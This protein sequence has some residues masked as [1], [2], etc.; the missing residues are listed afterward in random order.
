MNKE[1]L[2]RGLNEDLAAE[3]G[4]VI[5]YTYQSAKCCGLLAAELRELLIKEEQDEL[6]HAAFLMDVIEELESA[7]VNS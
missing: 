2:I 4:T 7:L 3:L 6:G 5:R 1:N